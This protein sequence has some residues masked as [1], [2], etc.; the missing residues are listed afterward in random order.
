M[1]ASSWSS[2]LTSPRR[3]WARSSALRSRKTR[4]AADDLDLVRDVVPDEL[5]Q[6]QRA[7]DA[8]D[9]REHVRAERVLQLGVLVEV[10]QHDLGDGVAL[11]HDDQSLAEP[12][13]ALV[14]DVGDAADAGRP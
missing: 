12:L 14:A 5:V 10:V 1:T 4:A 13:V 9:E 2:A 6:A 3:M 7:R 11:E 8:V